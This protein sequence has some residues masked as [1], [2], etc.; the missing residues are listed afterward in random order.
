M[1]PGAGWC[2]STGCWRRV[3]PCTGPGT[4]TP[5][6]PPTLPPWTGWAGRGGGR[7]LGQPPHPPPPQ[8]QPRPAEARPHPRGRGRRL[9]GARRGSRV[10]RGAGDPR[11]G[12]PRRGSGGRGRG[13]L[14][15]GA[16]AAAHQPNCLPG[17]PEVARRDENEKSQT[18]IL[19]SILRLH[20]LY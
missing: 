3:T 6:P 13:G 20:R 19:L 9:R 7:G 15:R 12:R 8:P 10:C 18:S 4:S 17:V 1:L 5:P 11:Q 2:C 16:P 14:R